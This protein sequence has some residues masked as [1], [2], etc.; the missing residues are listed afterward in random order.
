MTDR[1]PS[2]DASRRSARGGAPTPAAPQPLTAA[3]FDRALRVHDLVQLRAALTA[4]DGRPVLIVSGRG[5]GAHAGAG[6]WQALLAAAEGADG[7]MTAL[8]CGE[9]PGPVLAAVRAGVADILCRPEAPDAGTSG[10][11]VAARLAALAAA[12]GCRLWR[13][14]LP[15]VLDLG[16][17]RDPAAA[18]RR[19]IDG[20]PPAAPPEDGGDRG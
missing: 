12:G 3:G 19:W 14:P 15:P 11:P 16:R 1:S 4:A 9:A 17:V 13:P 8:D 6:W 18:A 10:P 20:P 7:A 2:A 5:A